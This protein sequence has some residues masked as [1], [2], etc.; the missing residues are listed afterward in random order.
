[1]QLFV[2]LNYLCVVY[3]GI[4]FAWQV[5]SRTVILLSGVFMILM[6]M[7]GKIGAIFTTIPTPV[8]GGMFMVMFGVITAAGIANLQ[9]TNSMK[10]LFHCL[11]VL[12]YSF[13][14]PILQ[15]TDMNSSR[16]IFIFGFSMFSALVIPNW[17]MKNPDCLETGICH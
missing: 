17:V 11:Q 16:N 4:A 12:F 15:S 9:V 10:S 3:S 6:G 13:N 8:I 1:M 2:F 7:L 14:N 5:G